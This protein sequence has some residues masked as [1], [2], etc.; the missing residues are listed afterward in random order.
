MIFI[1]RDAKAHTL[2]G[3]AIFSITAPGP[4]ASS[5]GGRAGSTG[6]VASMAA[7]NVDALSL[8]SHRSHL[9]QGEIPLPI[10]P[11][12]EREM[13]VA[14]ARTA[15]GYAQT[16]CLWPGFGCSLA[17]SHAPRPYMRKIPVQSCCCT[18][19]VSCQLPGTVSTSCSWHFPCQFRLQMNSHKVMLRQRLHIPRH[20]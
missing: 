17:Q 12:S 20:Q 5:A 15:A 1:F 19:W 9:K 7:A 2:G 18:H 11:I 6:A 10:V 13:N 4:R 3:S 16:L 14:S 8:R